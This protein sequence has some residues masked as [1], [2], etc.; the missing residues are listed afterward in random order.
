MR[1]ER[2]GAKFLFSADGRIAGPLP[3]RPSVRRWESG[4]TSDLC[5]RLVDSRV[6][7]PV[8]AARVVVAAAAWNKGAGP[9]SPSRRSH[10]WLRRGGSGVGGLQID[11]FGGPFCA[12]R[13]ADRGCF[14]SLRVAVEAMSPTARVGDPVFRPCRRRGVASS[15]GA[16]G[17][18]KFWCVGGKGGGGALVFG[19]ARWGVLQ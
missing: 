2:E 11:R 19:G 15:C 8:G 10:A 4:G 18:V 3:L 17:L 1:G 7:L 14:C 9:S 5:L 16:A 12:P 13:S 6:W